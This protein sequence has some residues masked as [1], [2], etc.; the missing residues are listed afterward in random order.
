M[1]FRWV[2]CVVFFFGWLGCGWSWGGGKCGCC[3]FWLIC[4]FWVVLCLGIVDVRWLVLLCSWL[5]LFLGL[6]RICWFWIVVLCWLIVCVGVCGWFWFGFCCLVGWFVFVVFSCVWCEVWL[7][8]CVYGIVDWLV[9]VVDV[10]NVCLD[11]CWLLMLYIV[12]VY[13]LLGWVLSGMDWGWWGFW[14]D[15]VDW[16]EWGCKW[17][18]WLLVLVVCDGIGYCC[19]R[20]IVLGYFVCVCL[21]LLKVF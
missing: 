8:G 21:L 9:L 20:K 11:I 4:Y 7:D 16:L 14:V 19:L 1:W 5:G 6:G 18:F 3:N 15:F 2:D 10:G 12:L 17:C 13:V